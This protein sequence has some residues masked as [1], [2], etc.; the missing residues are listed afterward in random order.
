MPAV[1]SAITE[2]ARKNERV[3]LQAFARVSQTK[4]AELMGVSDST[5]TRLKDNGSIEQAC[6]LMAA[7]GLKVVPTDMQCF[8]QDK[9][10]ALLTLA[11]AH[12]EGIEHP[13]QLTWE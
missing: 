4:V 12:L 9:V 7:C 1:S 2:T 13:E 11:K 3:V 10:H 8:P 6:A 5:I